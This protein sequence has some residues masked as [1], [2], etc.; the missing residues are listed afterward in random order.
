MWLWDGLMY[1]P[2]MLREEL[3]QG[4][5]E[6]QEGGHFGV[7]RTVEKITRNYYFSGLYKTVQKVIGKYNICKRTKYEG[8]TPYG[9]YRASHHPN[10][11]GRG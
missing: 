5:H 1:V 11:P 4:H 3:V 8:H 9:T 2:T 6:D 7:E 10:E